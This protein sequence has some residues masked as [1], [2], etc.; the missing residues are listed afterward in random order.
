MRRPTWL[1]RAS[2]LALILAVPFFGGGC[3]CGPAHSPAA[4]S[5]IV[6]TFTISTVAIQTDDKD[7]VPSYLM[8]MTQMAPEEPAGW[9]NLGLYY[10]RITTWRR[11]PT[12]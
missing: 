3:G 4:Y 2:L 8:M 10:L 1:I 5:T 11:P 12:T 7:H 9:A 6:S